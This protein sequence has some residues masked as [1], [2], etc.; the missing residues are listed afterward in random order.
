MRA[1]KELNA[2]RAISMP[3]IGPAPYATRVTIDPH[4]SNHRQPT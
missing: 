3:A 2:A 1:A 4:G